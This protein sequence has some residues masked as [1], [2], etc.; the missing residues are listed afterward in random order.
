MK[1]SLFVITGLLLAETVLLCL[2]LGE[3]YGQQ[4][5]LGEVSLDWAVFWGGA[6]RD[7]PRG[8]VHLG[9]HLYVTGSTSSFG[10]GKEDVLLLK[11]TL[12]GGLVWNRTWGGKGYDMGRAIAATDESL[13][14]V[15]ITYPGE[16]SAA[17]LLKH[18][19]DGGL[20]WSR[21]WGA[22]ENAK[23]RGVAVDDEGF[24]YVAGYTLGIGSNATRSFLLKYRPDG[25]LM[26]NRTW[27]DTGS[28][29]CWAVAVDD[30]VYVS[31][32]SGV[33]ELLHEI[34][35]SPYE[36]KSEIYLTKFDLYG[37]E[38]WTHAWGKG[39]ENNGLALSA[40]KGR[41]YQAGSTLHANGSADVVLLE[42]D[43]SG[44][45][46]S[47]TICGGPYE[48]CAW[49]MTKAGLHVYVV[50]HSF[51]PEPYCLR[52]ALVSKFDLDGE[53][54]WSRTWGGMGSDTARSVSVVGD[55]VYV[56][57][58][59][60]GVGGDGQAF[61]LKYTSPNDSGDP[62]AALMLSVA[63][64]A[65]GALFWMVLVREILHYMK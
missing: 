5:Q 9:G 19:L 38:V 29:Y 59:T 12:D 13:Y 15:G 17:V 36:V 25:D 7:Y 26:W 65:V 22:D 54:V 31:G 27:G 24:V 14:V 58:I 35:D 52:D 44:N 57:G 28:D 46:R 49:G 37:N 50:G 41:V 23:G 16:R 42:Y 60:Y 11:Y 2:Y 39:I 33:A 53:T 32:T 8:I 21:M 18:D 10:A 62:I 47:A 64:I 51:N 4:G 20:V 3:L 43:A 55:G 40:S 61:L 48:E 34:G 6:G 30:G 45:L 63:I 1:R 56:A